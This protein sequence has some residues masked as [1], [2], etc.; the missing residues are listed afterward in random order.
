MPRGAWSLPV[1]QDVKLLRGIQPVPGNPGCPART[2]RSCRSAR[3]GSTRSTWRAALG[4]SSSQMEDVD[5]VE[6]G[7]VR[8]PSSLVP[9]MTGQPG[10]RHVVPSRSAGSSRRRAPGPA[11]R[12]QHLE[13][14]GG[15]VA[16][17]HLRPFQRVGADPGEVA[18]PNSF[19]VC[20]FA[21]PHAELGIVGEVDPGGERVEEVGAGRVGGLDTAT[22]RK[23]VAGPRCN[24]VSSQRLAS[25]SWSTIGSPG[26][27]RSCARRSRPRS[28]RCSRSSRAPALV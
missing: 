16:P 21:G 3:A 20:R 22:H 13:C 26:C 2:G 15:R 17:E 1:G 8:A 23:K 27:P 10:R 24:W 19:V 5:A 25:W 18:R 9:T 4:R 14:L 28:S 7:P 6:W 12:D 11:R